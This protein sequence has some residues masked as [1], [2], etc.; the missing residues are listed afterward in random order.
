MN[1]ENRAADKAALSYSLADGLTFTKH[2]PF[3]LF[4]QPLSQFSKLPLYIYLLFSSLHIHFLYP[5]LLYA[6]QVCH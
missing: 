3:L 2:G 1:A 4:L 6:K 5:P